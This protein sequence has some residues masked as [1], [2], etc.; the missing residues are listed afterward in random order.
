MR[1]VRRRRASRLVHRVAAGVLV[2]G[3]V[4][5]F[6]TAAAYGQASISVSPSTGLTGGKNVTVTGSGLAADV[7]GYILECN[8][9]PGEPTIGIGPPFDTRVPVGCS[10]PSL[11][12]I[13]RTSVSGTLAVT[14]RVHEGRKVGPPCGVPPVIGGC[15][16]DDSAHLHPHKDAQNYPCPP[17]PLQ[18]EAGFT[19]VLTWIDTAG[20][21]PSTKI[22]FLG[23]ITPTPPGASSGSPPPTSPGSST[24][25][26]TAASGTPH[27]S[28]TP[29][30]P[31]TRVGTGTSGSGAS[32]SP[33]S[34]VGTATAPARAAT[35]SG[36][37]PGTVSANSGSLAFTGLGP[38]G[39][40][41]A[42]A[43]TL[44]LVVGTLLF[45]VD[46]RRLV[47]WLLG[48]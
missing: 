30:V 39:K 5:I 46:V 20:D 48:L 22:A 45:L 17:S 2:A 16:G 36:A 18:Q 3:G 19:C 14:F 33:G 28:T 37:A 35:S 15:R 27:G 10:A 40:L 6:G 42:G 7:P 32:G 23:A 13:A 34:G 25:P 47:T 43:G 29:S 41:I 26:T 4:S 8:T 21:H 31:V 38:Y 12:R 9:T 1:A 24:T 44:F 11:R